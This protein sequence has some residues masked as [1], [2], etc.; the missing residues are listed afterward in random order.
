[1]INTGYFGDRFAAPERYGAQ[2]TQVRA[3][4]GGRPTLDAVE[5]G[6]ASSATS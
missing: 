6:P 3:P 1:M 5:D 4:V 2:V